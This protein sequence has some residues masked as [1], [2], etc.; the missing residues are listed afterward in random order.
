M[1]QFEGDEEEDIQKAVNEYNLENSTAIDRDASIAVWRALK[2]ITEGIPLNLVLNVKNE[3][4]IRAWVKLAK[5]FLVSLDGQ[6]GAALTE[7][8]H[9]SIKTADSPATTKRMLTEYESKVN[10]CEEITGRP[11]DTVHKKSVLLGFMDK[12]T[13]RATVQYHG[14][15]EKELFRQILLYVNGVTT[16]A[17]TST[18]GAVPMQIG[19]FQQEQNEHAPNPKDQEYNQENY[20]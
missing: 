6:Q 11:L 8:M 19:R 1:L 7:L 9:M 20:P 2:R 18:S 4:G 15:D 5:H 3:N 16:P 12:E 13:R 14:S 10:F 17:S